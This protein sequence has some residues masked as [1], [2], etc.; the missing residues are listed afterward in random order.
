MKG[1]PRRKPG[2]FEDLLGLLDLVVGVL[3]LALLAYLVVEPLLLLLLLLLHQYECRL[4][5]VFIMLGI[6][7]QGC[8]L[9]CWWALPCGFASSVWNLFVTDVVM[10]ARSTSTAKALPE[11]GTAAADISRE[12][13]IAGEIAV[14]QQSTVIIILTVLM[15]ITIPRQPL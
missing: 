7:F 14:P 2:D 6:P 12:T 13:S 5:Q 9:P 8:L 3:Q 15:D 1:R 11:V 4:R 10:C